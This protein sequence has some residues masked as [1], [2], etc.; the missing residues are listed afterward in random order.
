[1]LPTL[2]QRLPL[3]RLRAVAAAYPIRELSVF[4]SAL[5]AAFRPDSDL[6]LLVAFEPDAE[7]GFLLLAE[8]QERLS[9]VAGRRV[10]LVPKDG[11]KPILKAPVLDAARVIYAR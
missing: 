5:G 2:A 4:G 9:A 10:D 6:D 8:I 7:V 11:L 1:M 3:A